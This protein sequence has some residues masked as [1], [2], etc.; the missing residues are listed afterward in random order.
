VSRF[1]WFVFVVVV[2]PVSALCA[3]L[4][5]FVSAQA[6]D[7]RYDRKGVRCARV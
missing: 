3:V 4:G 2:A 7:R 5:Y 1:G 6:L